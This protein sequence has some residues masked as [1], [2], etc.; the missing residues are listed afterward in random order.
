M[1]IMDLHGKLA[2]TVVGSFPLDKTQAN[3]NRVITDQIAIGIDFPGV[4]QLEDM[5]TMFLEPLVDQGCGV[6]F[7]N[8]KPCIVGDLRIPRYPIAT[9][10]L[11]NAQKFLRNNGHQDSIKGMKVCV[12]GPFTLAEQIRVN[13]GSAIQKPYCVE[14]LS[15]I[16]R[17]FV[18]DFDRYGADIITVDE[19][20]L[21]FGI[22]F[23]S[24]DDEL[25]LDCL[26]QVFK[27]ITRSTSS[28]HVCG[29][30]FCVNK[31]LLEV[32][33]VDYLDHEFANNPSNLKGYTKIELERHDK[34]IGFGCIDTS[35]DPTLY[36]NIRRG[37]IPWRDAIESET[38][39]R[40]RIL[41]AIDRYGEENIVVDPDCG[42]G[43]LK[44]YIPSDQ[45]YLVTL[46]KLRKMTSVVKTLRKELHLENFTQLEVIV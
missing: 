18:S 31:L 39:V 3:T 8:N 5:N 6:E 27:D 7:I 32:D 40:K 15:Q 12:T 37:I 36:E 34:M 33:K 23:F 46:E 35:I 13:G 25:I 2:T 4:P 19:P 43:S 14:L 29:D 28:I 21:N 9:A 11:R 10:G 24:L 30:V 20:V 45:A 1:K 44:S 38:E 26:N 42:F 16:V 41:A 17:K 22:S